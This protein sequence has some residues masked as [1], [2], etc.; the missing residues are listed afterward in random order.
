MTLAPEQVTAAILAGGAGR[1]MGG[2]D[3]GLMRR[4][5]APLVK[6]L[7]QQLQPD[8]CA[9][10]LSI[11]RN[12]PAYQAVL[13]G[14]EP[15][16]GQRMGVVTDATADYAGPMAGVRAVW[17]VCSTPY[18]LLVPGDAPGLPADFVQ[19]MTQAL[20][21]QATRV[22]V[23]QVGQDRHYTACLLQRDAL[24]LPPG[25]GSLRD[26]LSLTPVGTAPMPAATRLSINT[27]AEAADCG[28][29]PAPEPWV[30]VA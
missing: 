1:R 19:R 12:V 21:L 8:V 5:G 30:P 23:A 28:V 16:P 11:H 10:W 24:P 7:I 2:L 20:T 14:I 29:Q 25:R 9:L 22:V 26:W 15:R 3:K 27:P 18:L 17:K 4:A 6:T 13:D